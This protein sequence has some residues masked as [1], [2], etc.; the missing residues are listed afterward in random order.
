V[1]EGATWSHSAKAVEVL[2]AFRNRLHHTWLVH[3][4]L[5]L[6][7]RLWHVGKLRVLDWESRNDPL[8][9]WVTLILVRRHHWPNVVVLLCVILVSNLL[10]L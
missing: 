9:L 10:P 1:Q 6:R 5:H 3:G 2:S 7:P 4:Q 8:V